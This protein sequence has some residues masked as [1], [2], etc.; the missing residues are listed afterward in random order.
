MKC[1]HCGKEVSSKAITCPFCGKVL[2]GDYYEE[3]LRGNKVCEECGNTIQGGMSKCPSCGC[4]VQLFVKESRTTEKASERSSGKNTSSRT[5]KRI[6]VFLILCIIVLVGIL[7]GY[8]MV[9]RERLVFAVQ[10]MMDGAEKS[11]IACNLVN[12]VWYNSIYMISDENT[13]RFTKNDAGFV[14]DFNDA[15]DSL[16]EDTQY[17]KTVTEIQNNRNDVV[18]SIKRLQHP[19]LGMKESFSILMELY[20][21]YYSLTVM[22]LHPTGS[23][24]SYN[25]NLGILLD[26]I[27]KLYYELTIN[28]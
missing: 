28:I 18:L 27:T 9:Y 23:Y 4:P 13:D 14:D 15:L 24:S 2:M 7:I 8:R 5:V 17:Q 1:K 3:Q 26:Q 12:D 20:D 6:L 10:E 11:E 19:P 16:F 21:A 25:E 22:A